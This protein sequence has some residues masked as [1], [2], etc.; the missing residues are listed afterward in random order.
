MTERSEVSDAF[1]P[2]KGCQ[3]ISTGTFGAFLI[4]GISLSYAV[5]Q[6]QEVPSGG[7]KVVG[8]M[9]T[10]ISPLKFINRDYFDLLMILAIGFQYMVTWEFLRR[11][12]EQMLIALTALVGVWITWQVASGAEWFFPSKTA[13]FLGWQW[14]RMEVAFLLFPAAGVLLFSWPLLQ[15]LI[16]K[17]KSNKGRI[18]W[19][20]KTSF[21]R[22]LSGLSLFTAVLF[23]SYRHP[24]YLDPYY[25]NWRFTCAYLYVAFAVLGWPYS[26]VTNLVRHDKSEDRD[27]PCFVLL[28]IHVSLFRSIRFNKLGPVRTV[29]GNRRVQIA[30][31][32]LL[33]KF[34]FV[35]LMVIFLYNNYGEMASS[36]RKLYGPERGSSMDIFNAW[37]FLIFNVLFVV[38]VGLS[39]I[40]YV[41]SS[42]WLG[43]KSV[44]VEGTVLGWMVA[45]MCYPP[46]AQVTSN[47][48]PYDLIKGNPFQI[49]QH[50]WISI[51]LKILTLI[52]LGVYVWATMAFGLRFSNLTHRGIIT[53][54]PYAWVRHPAYIAK[55]IA[56]WTMS[57]Q[58][59]S[60]PLQFLFL[61]LWNVVYYVRAVTEERH[62]GQDPDYRAYCRHVKYKFIPGVW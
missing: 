10:W 44:S 15:F 16:S 55:N 34:F 1:D 4:L 13:R 42:R 12:R 45:V 29:F 40:G 22:W 54:G 46:F 31:R 8:A 17:F 39:L 53:R 49:L 30:L 20:I 62:L 24:F 56:W 3:R 57:I 41:C 6:S 60:G 35:P 61:A 25:I 48:L 51:P 38:D 58:G 26:F 28:L 5:Y 59:F 36:V 19:A 37:Y 14:T 7:P 2:A 50:D 21:Y 11:R 9:S 33:V 47:Y 23:L 32:D 27:D 18:P 52:F 43:N